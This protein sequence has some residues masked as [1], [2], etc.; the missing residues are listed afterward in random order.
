MSDPVDYDV[1]IVGAGPAGASLAVELAGDGAAVALVD[2]EKSPR[3]KCCAGW[4]NA[5]GAQRFSSLD[6][7]RRKAKAA[8]FR[9]LVFHSADLSETAVHSSRSHLGYVVRRETFDALLLKQ[10]ESAGAETHLGRRVVGVETG[11][12]RATVH[13]DGGKSV[14]ARILVGADG[15]YS[16]VARLAGLRER[17]PPGQIV[18]C[19]ARGVKLTK[20]QL[21][22]GL[23]EAQIHVALG[24]G[25]AAGYAWAFPGR[26][27]ANIGLG[28]CGQDGAKRLPELYEKW[29][30]GLKEA[31]LLPEKADTSKPCGGAVPAGAALEFENH[32]GKRT[33]LVGDAGGFAAAASGEG[34]YPGVWSASIAAEC[35][36]GALEADREKRPARTCQD[37]LLKFRRAWRCQMAPYLQMPNVNVQFLVPLIFTNQEIADRFARAFLFGENL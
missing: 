33:L 10:A 19:L 7:A 9:R 15:A 26:G 34:I 25:G 23:G 29:A 12:H 37:E 13:L 5:L 14:T 1:L 6:A 11:E 20:R 27:Y 28:I 24:F 17:W 2:A 3:T 8:P 21:G 16:E 18:H 31:G 22:A 36:R 4:L 35:I 30:A 32:V